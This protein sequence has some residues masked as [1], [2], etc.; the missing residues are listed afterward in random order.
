MNDE[1]EHRESS[2]SQLIVWTTRERE[3]CAQFHCPPQIVSVPKIVHTYLIYL[4]QYVILGRFYYVYAKDE[5]TFLCDKKAKILLEQSESEM[6]SP[7]K[8]E[9]THVCGGI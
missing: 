8:A 7:F 5:K 1:I 2:K 3:F 6:K 4:T 9:S